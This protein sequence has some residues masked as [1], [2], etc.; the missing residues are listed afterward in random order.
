[1]SGVTY[2]HR[3]WTTHTIER[4]WVGHAIIAFGQHTRSKDVGR[5]MTSHAFGQ[6]TVT[7]RQIPRQIATRLRSQQPLEGGQTAQNGQQA[8]GQASKHAADRG[9]GV[10]AVTG[11]FSSYNRFISYGRFSSYSMW[12]GGRF[13]P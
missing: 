9:S 2:H 1:M 4:R 10:S 12:G 3:L 6:H 7:T 13:Q 11:S 8:K 5:G